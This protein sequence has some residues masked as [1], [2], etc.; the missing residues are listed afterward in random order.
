MKH[1]PVTIKSVKFGFSEDRQSNQ[2]QFKSLREADSFLVGRNSQ[3]RWEELDGYW[4]TDFTI[5]FSNDETYTGRY[6]I[7][8][9]APTLTDHVINYL[10]WLTQRSP[11]RPLDPPQYPYHDT[12]EA[13][14]ILNIVLATV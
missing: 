8:G 10:K 6:D 13:A 5:T 4:K 7:G 1:E 3:A 14:G 11:N 2:A 9:D 12:R